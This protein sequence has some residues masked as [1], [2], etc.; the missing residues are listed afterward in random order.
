MPK[1]KKELDFKCPKCGYHEKI[2][3]E[4]VQNFFG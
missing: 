1:L 2:T 3:V 4:G